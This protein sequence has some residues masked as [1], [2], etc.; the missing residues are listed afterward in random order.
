MSK[1]RFLHNMM[2]WWKVGS[3]ISLRDSPLWK[4]ARPGKREVRKDASSTRP[5][6]AP[7]GSS[8]CWPFQ[9]QWVIGW[10]TFSH[11]LARGEAAPCSYSRHWRSWWL[12]ASADHI[13]FSWTADP[14]LRGHLGGATL[15]V[16]GS[17]LLDSKESFWHKVLA[18]ICLFLWA[19]RE[20]NKSLW[21]VDT[22]RIGAFRLI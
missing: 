7:R 10:V 3:M 21:A 6:P 15:S 14:S 9:P 12:E 22:F 4:E 13:I 16:T 19:C 2:L 17:Y 18:G 20:L 5:Q 8:E 11:C 1:I